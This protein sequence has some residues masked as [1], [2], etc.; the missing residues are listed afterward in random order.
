MSH[1]A[2]ISKPLLGLA[3]GTVLGLLD[4]LTGFFW[5]ELKPIMVSVIVVSTVKGLMCGMAIGFVA[6]RVQSLPLGILA[7]IGIG[8]LLSYLVALTAR[9]GLFWD[10]VLPGALLG[11]IVGV[12]TQKFGKP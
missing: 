3:L 6:L 5:A 9:P 8:A 11:L 7:G 2:P 10:I 12:A 4:G 1:R